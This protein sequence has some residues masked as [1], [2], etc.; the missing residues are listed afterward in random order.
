MVD[1]METKKTCKISVC[2]PTYNRAGL[3]HRV[4]DSLVS[5]TYQNFEWI[6]VD[7]GSTDKTKE[8]VAKYIKEGKIKIRYIYKENGGKHSAV[9]IGVQNASGEFFVIADSDDGF[10]VNSF[11]TL[12]L[13]WENI[14]ENEKSLY[15]GIACRCKDQQGRLVG[16]NIP[17]DIS[18][19]KNELDVKYKYKYRFELW[20]MTKTEILRAYPFPSIKGL[21]F[22]PEAVIWD[23]ISRKYNTKYI[24]DALRIYYLDQVDSTTY[25]KSS[26]RYKENYF[27]WLHYLNDISDYMKYV[28]KEYIKAIVGVSRDGFLGKKTLRN[29]IKDIKLWYLKL[30][31]LCCSPFGWILSR[32]CS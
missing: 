22:F 16:E 26:T 7:D 11:A 27:L 13:E 1:N 28:P 30:M 23:N 5:Q 24:N 4:Y 2:T 25:E 14:P 6:V 8:V 31:V 21:R 15:R 19:C 9:N 10:E 12:M 32:L 20:G 3:L 17:G 18:I 29:I